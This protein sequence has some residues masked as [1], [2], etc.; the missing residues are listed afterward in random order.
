M[1]MEDEF[2]VHLGNVL[3]YSWRNKTRGGI[4]KVVRLPPCASD[5][6]TR[7]GF[8]VCKISLFAS[9]HFTYSIK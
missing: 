9:E 6:G 7:E 5:T 4:D 1:R 3:R 2:I 8:P